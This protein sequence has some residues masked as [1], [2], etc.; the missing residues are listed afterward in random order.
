MLEM[1][2]IASGRPKLRHII[3]GT[4][5]P[6]FILRFSLQGVDGGHP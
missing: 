4:V 5:F 1:S 3:T 2:L 6:S